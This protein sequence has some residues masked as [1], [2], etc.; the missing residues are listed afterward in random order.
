MSLETE[1]ADLKVAANA[2]LGDVATALTTVNT[3]LARFVWMDDLGFDGS[4]LESTIAG[5]NAAIDTWI[6][7]ATANPGTIY[8]A[9]RG[10]DI[11]RISAINKVLPGAM[12][13]A[14]EGARF[15]WGGDL[16]GSASNVF[17]LGSG[18]R[19]DAFRLETTEGSNWRRLVTVNSCT[20]PL[21]EIVAQ[22][23][24]GIYGNNFDCSLYVQGD[25]SG[26]DRIRLVNHF[27]PAQFRGVPG[28]ATPMRNLRIDD[29]DVDTYCKG[30]VFNNITGLRA[31]GGWIR[32]SGTGKTSNPG[33]N[34]LLLG[35]L[36]DAVIQ[37]F[38]CDDAGEHGIRLG[39]WGVGEQTNKGVRILKCRTKNT[40][41][42]G[43]K[44]Y[45]GVDDGALWQEDI[46][47]G[48]CEVVNP[49]ARSGAG[50]WND[51][52]FLIQ[53]CKNSRAYNL[54]VFVDGG[55]PY[56]GMWISQCDNFHLRGYDYNQIAGAPAA[57]ALVISEG[58]G[59]ADIYPSRPTYPINTVS[60]LDMTARGHSD[61]A[62]YVDIPIDDARD[63]HVR[64]RAFGG[65]DVV[66]WA[67]AGARADQRCILEAG[68]RG[69]TGSLFNVPGHPNLIT[70]NL[71]SVIA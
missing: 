43:I 4:G 26:F 67:G 18:M 51:L 39:G 33:F 56:A 70:R 2:L 9:R 16:S 20:F 1:V 41:Q 48:D 37:G 59:P 69:F 71:N 6:A 3:R 19:G 61:E 35:A 45:T 40:G 68:G 60:V 14:F 53:Q 57:R 11:W 30:P 47:L 8:R 17:T 52:G 13:L 58:N 25:D 49:R 32:G 27:I 44:V 38:Q 55:N 66:R 21:L 64:C 36:R 63:L 29:L 31:R 12:R 42:T 7:H 5:N 62:V 22:S 10:T 46:T 28:S 24:G 15:M 54:S 50:G 23:F 65:S 34:S